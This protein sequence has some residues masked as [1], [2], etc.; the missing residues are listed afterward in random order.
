[1]NMVWALFEEGRCNC[2]TER[3]QSDRELKS[4]ARSDH[5]FQEGIG[6]QSRADSQRVSALTTPPEPTVPP[7]QSDSG[8]G[9]S[10]L[11]P[12]VSDDPRNSSA[13]G[14]YCC[15]VV[16]HIDYDRDPEEIPPRLSSHSHVPIFP[17][18]SQCA[19]S[20]DPGLMSLSLEGP[21]TTRDSR[22]LL[23]EA[24]LSVNQRRDMS[25][26]RGPRFWTGAAHVTA[27]TSP[28]LSRPW[29][30]RR[31]NRIKPLSPREREMLGLAPE[32]GSWGSN[33]ADPD[34]MN[35]RKEESMLM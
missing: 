4:N 17:S 20:A 29:S 1:M 23:S 26:G 19:M 11:N 13:L 35:G 9:G 8:S 22:A 2:A 14:L 27:H 15:N 25:P 3:R 18:E 24:S 30:G 32:V 6:S 16:E 34:S 5:L 12:T 10:R 21:T 31:Q 28:P 33:Y 7:P